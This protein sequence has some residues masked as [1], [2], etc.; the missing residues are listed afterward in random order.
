MSPLNLLPPRA[1]QKQ[2]S[3]RLL[4]RLAVTETLIVLCLAAC[5]FAFNHAARSVWLR[6]EALERELNS[7]KYSESAQVAEQLK[8]A[9][10]LD[11]ARVEI[12]G[13]LPDTWF[14]YAKLAH[15]NASA[16]E[17]AAIVYVKMSEASV[18][19]T[20]DAADLAAME[21]HR[22]KLEEGGL[23]TQARLGGVSRLDNGNYRYTLT[24]GIN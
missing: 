11:A 4:I 1:V 8:A 16:P 24:C 10:A 3:R 5:V 22:G 12:T 18:T 9:A 15:M 2:N 20:A 13:A 6:S 17:G 21:I 19:V 14:D 7:G 23:F